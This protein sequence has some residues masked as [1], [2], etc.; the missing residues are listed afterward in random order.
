MRK[1]IT[2]PRTYWGKESRMCALDAGYT[3]SGM[4]DKIYQADMQQR[5]FCR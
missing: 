3:A 2:A 5:L 4:R 1:H